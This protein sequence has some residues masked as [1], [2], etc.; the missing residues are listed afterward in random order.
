MLRMALDRYP[1]DAVIH[2]LV[3]QIIL[4]VAKD[5]DG[6]LLGR[7]TLIPRLEVMQLLYRVIGIKRIIFCY[8]LLR[9]F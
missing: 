4:T 8:I 5:S 2:T 7:K 1:K 6:I 9:Q 3:L